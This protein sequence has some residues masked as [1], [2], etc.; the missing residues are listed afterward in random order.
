MD[1]LE[2]ENLAQLLSMQPSADRSFSGVQR[3][4]RSAYP[5]NFGAGF[6]LLVTHRIKRLWRPKRFPDAGV[7]SRWREQIACLLAQRI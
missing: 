7:S 5:F 4:Q 3:E 2:F 1:L 6:L